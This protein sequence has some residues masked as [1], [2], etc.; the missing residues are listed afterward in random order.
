MK[1]PHICNAPKVFITGRCVARQR[2][3]SPLSD[4]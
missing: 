4:G 2:E 3:S 1:D